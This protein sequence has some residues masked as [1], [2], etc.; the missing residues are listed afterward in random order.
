MQNKRNRSRVRRGV[1]IFIWIL[2][3]IALGPSLVGLTRAAIACRVWDTPDSAEPAS[4]DA[5]VREAVKDIPDYARAEDL[6]FLTLPE[7]YIVYST[8]E[9]AAFI[10]DNPPSQFPHLKAVGQYWQSY[11]EVCG[12]V[13]G[14][15]PPN[16][17]HQFA[18][19][20]IGV[21]FTA[22]NMLKGVYEGTIG[23]F[24]EWTSSQPTEEEVYATQVAKEY[25]DFLHMTPW[26]FFP[27][28]DKLQDLW[29]ETDLWGPGP[30]R[31]WERKLS[32]T[33]EYGL[34]AL[35]AGLTKF[36]A[37][38]TYGGPDV[39]KIY[40]VTEGLT[41]EMLSSDLELI[42][43]IDGSRQLIRMT[44]FEV[45]TQVVPDL[46]D[47]G[48]SFIEIAGN[49]EILV[50]VFASRSEEYSLAHGEYLFNLPILTNPDLTRVAVKVR[51][52]NLRLFLDELEKSP[53]KLEH[54]Y[55][56]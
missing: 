18:L 32:L 38:A 52:E 19:G 50:T 2:L 14:K 29:T 37:E 15:Y 36:G 8:D 27:F 30:I 49:D 55:D 41:N 17:G 51:L 11:Y 54:L 22:E 23:R 42:K 7:W 45:F 46:T 47:N 44:R 4:T 39:S 3:A 53:S 10:A 28:G 5:L 48:L 16:G 31:K 33:T 9:Y 35:Y 21:S 25:G 13:R 40:A 1:R 26:Y 12:I 20:F 24:A 56:Y 6:T 34:K 43:E